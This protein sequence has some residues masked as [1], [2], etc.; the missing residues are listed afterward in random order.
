[1]LSCWSSL[2]LEEMLRQKM[3]KV[4]ASTLIM[5][6]LMLPLQGKVRQYAQQFFLLSTTQC[7]S[8]K[9]RTD[10]RTDSKLIQYESS[11]PN[12]KS[13]NIHLFSFPLPFSARGWS[14]KTSEIHETFMVWLLKPTCCSGSLRTSLLIPG[15]AP[16]KPT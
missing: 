6:W 14:L 3:K 13:D 4:P 12:G 11:E 16:T 2:L 8:S 10:Q 15:S 9:P 1:M 7:Q 5:E